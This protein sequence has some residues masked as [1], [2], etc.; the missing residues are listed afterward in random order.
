[1]RRAWS[2]SID[3]FGDGREGAL[4][5]GGGHGLTR[6]VGGLGFGLS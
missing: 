2:A 6:E 4:V 1:M 3:G 5:D